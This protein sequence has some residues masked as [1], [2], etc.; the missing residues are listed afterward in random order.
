MLLIYKDLIVNLFVKVDD[1]CKKA[2]P[3]WNGYLMSCNNV[4]DDNT[5]DNNS[6][7]DDNGNNNVNDN[8]NGNC[9]NIKKEKSIDLE[10][11]PYR[12]VK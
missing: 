6:N 2:I 3:P 12:K 4:K 11:I 8:V 5:R 7:G 10:K 1:F 9:N